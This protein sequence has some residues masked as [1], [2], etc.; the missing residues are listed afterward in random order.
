MRARPPERAR[1]TRAEVGEEEAEAAV[2]RGRR[3]PGGRLQGRGGARRRPRRSHPDG[4]G[5][6]SADRKRAR[7]PRVRLELQH[8]SIPMPADGHERARAFY[9]GVLGLEERDVPPKLDASELVWFRAGSD[10][11]MHVFASDGSALR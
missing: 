3:P 5:G 1:G 4:G 11:E 2:I 6:T 9:G 8:V 10:S 7:P